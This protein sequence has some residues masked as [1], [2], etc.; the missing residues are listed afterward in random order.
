[1]G[2]VGSPPGRRRASCQRESALDR[3]P[4]PPRSSRRLIFRA[5]P[6]GTDAAR[7]GP[8]RRPRRCRPAPA[9]AVRP[10]WCRRLPR[11]SETNRLD[12]LALCD[13]S[14]STTLALPEPEAG[15]SAPLL[16]QRRLRGARASD[17]ETN[18]EP[19][20]NPGVRARHRGAGGSRPD[21]LLRQ[22]VSSGMRPPGR[23]RIPRAGVALPRRASGSLRRGVASANG[24]VRPASGTGWVHGGSISGPPLVDRQ[25]RSSICHDVTA[26]I[27]RVWPVLDRR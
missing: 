16:D 14:Y 18:S 12:H 24:V 23:T 9:G 5:V 7:H 27:K 26:N 22:A 17:V 20:A 15:W 6:P 13:R 19:S 8:G 25:D 11:V 4:R 10:A 1:M 2:E 3:A 21:F